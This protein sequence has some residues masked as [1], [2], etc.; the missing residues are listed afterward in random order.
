MAVQG[1][2]FDL[3][4]SELLTMKAER[5]CQLKAAMNGRVN[6][7]KDV[8]SEVQLDLPSIEEIKADLAE[9]NAAL[10]RVDPATY[11]K[12]ITRLRPSFRHARI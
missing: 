10:K 11:G 4:E 2:Y 6:R 8:D 3:T 9:I 12:R 7:S 1:I 5:L